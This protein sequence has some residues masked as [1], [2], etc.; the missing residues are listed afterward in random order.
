M[1]S[2]F[3]FRIDIDLFAINI[4]INLIRANASLIKMILA[5]YRKVFHINGTL[6]VWV[7][8]GCKHA[9]VISYGIIRELR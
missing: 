7:H 8:V 1:G 6:A 9:I 3:I 4:I 2:G 5:C